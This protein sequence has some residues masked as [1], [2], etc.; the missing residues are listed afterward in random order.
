MKLKKKYLKQNIYN[1]KV[2]CFNNF[3]RLW[4]KNSLNCIKKKDSWLNPC[5]AFHKLIQIQPRISNLNNQIAA[6]CPLRK[7]PFPLH[8][9]IMNLLI[10]Y[11][12]P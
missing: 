2:Y 11:V 7:Q 10:Y 4:L 12:L 6:L 9:Q 5:E 1:N 3:I 8:L